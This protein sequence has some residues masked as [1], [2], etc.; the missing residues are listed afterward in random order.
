MDVR[1][2]LLDALAVLLPVECAGCGT[3]DRALCDPCRVALAPE[4]TR[5]DVGG[6]PVWA[7]LRYEGVA[8]TVLL[9]LKRDGRLDA[10]RALAPALAAAVGRVAA[11]PH[12]AGRVAAQPRIETPP[13]LIVPIPGSR[14]AYRR[15]GYDPVRLLLARAGIRCT[16]V[17]APARPHAAQKSLGVDDR[18][19]N[20]TGVFRLR[21][22]VTG[23]RILLV[24]DVV[25]T[26]AT[27]REAA[28]VLR[29][30]GAEVVGA[31]VVAS[32]PRR[33]ASADDALS[34]LSVTSAGGGTTL[35][36]KAS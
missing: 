14:R 28:R 12:P 9:S 1:E 26:G 35:G 33:T 30:A 34:R 4:V 36:R 16:R 20:L 27:L 24:D 11:Q 8:R 6:L 22:P 18:E 32:T 13:L 10:A 19:R 5:R 23:H 3:D 17:F 7:G 15:R 2:A 31:A 21:R 25:T 29:A